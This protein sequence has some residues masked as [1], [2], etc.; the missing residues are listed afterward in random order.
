M[1][2]REMFSMF[3]I[4]YVAFYGTHQFR[5]CLE[6]EKNLSMHKINKFRLTHK[7]FILCCH[8]SILTAHRRLRS[9]V[10]H[11]FESFSPRFFTVQ[12]RDS[13]PVLCIFHIFFVFTL[14]TVIY[15]LSKIK[16]MSFSGWL[17]M[18]AMAVVVLE[19]RFG[20]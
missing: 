4:K 2:P 3:N 1:S 7:L 17:T 5:S 16:E 12:R 6:E 19:K 13:L 14:K 15:H 8:T 9:F 18:W 11:S 20:D 10:L